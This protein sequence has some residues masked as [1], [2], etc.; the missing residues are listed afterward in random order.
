M[1]PLTQ[2]L[3]LNEDGSFVARTYRTPHFEVGWHQH[4]EHELILF[5]E[6]AGL[7]F[8]GNHVGEFETGDVY[9]LGSN[10]PHT[11]QKRDPDL[12][13][14]AVVVQFLDDF[15][16]GE[17]LRIPESRSIRLLLDEA[18][19]GLKICGS[20]LRQLAP[21]INQLE[22]AKGFTR[23]LL[24]GE[25]LHL[26]AEERT[27]EAVSTQDI[28]PNPGTTAIDRVFQYTI[29]SFREPITLRQAADIACMSVPAFCNYFKK[30][31][32]KTY[33]DFLNEVRIGF[34]CSLLVDTQ[35]SVSDICYESGY[36]TMANFH[37][38]FLKVKRMTPLQYR[39]A[40]AG[41]KASPM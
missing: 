30:C 39:K 13:T 15:W 2:K 19:H 11:F 12:V 16:G 7:S 6:G 38:Q 29:Q 8:V 20:L 9:L 10:L 1:K 31:T 17:F 28:R 23:I 26:I 41:A 34:A 25:C 4:T 21:R 18:R 27:F 32:K 35:A 3:P 22:H 37:K 5:T 40:F 36:N 24:L 14:S 33:I